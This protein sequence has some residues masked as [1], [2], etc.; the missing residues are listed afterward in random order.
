M[1]IIESAYYKSPIGIVKITTDEYFVTGLVF[2]DEETT[3]LTNCNIIPS[4][5][6]QQC[7]QQLD[8]FFNGERKHF[9]IPLKQPGTAFQQRVWDELANIPFGKTVSY[10]QLSKQLGDAKAIRA[11]AASNGKNKISIL[12]PCHRVV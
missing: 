9:T 3:G 11:V 12:V 2:T 4:L 8:E 5:P 10:L 7:R 1:A 6:L